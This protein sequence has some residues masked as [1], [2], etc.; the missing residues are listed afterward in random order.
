MTDT[1]KTWDAT[2]VVATAGHVWFARSVTYDGHLYHLHGARIVRAWGTS[3]GLNELVRGPTKST[4]LDQ[5]APLVSVVAPAMIAL[6]PC[7]PGSWAG[8]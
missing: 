2:L 5:E 3:K 1:Q 4:V 8:K 7:D 6:I